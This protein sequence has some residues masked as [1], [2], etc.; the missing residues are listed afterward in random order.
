MAMSPSLNGDMQEDTAI[1]EREH[2]ELDHD[3][4]SCVFFSMRFGDEHGVMPMAVQLRSALYERGYYAKIV[5]MVSGGD[6][7]AEVFRWIEH[8][9]TF[10]V[11]GS[12]H[13]GENTGNQ[14]CTY[15]EYKHAFGKKKRI[16]LIRMIPSSE[17]FREL[18]AR[19]IFNANMMTLRWTI[20]TPMHPD[21]ADRIVDA[22][23]RTRSSR[24]PRKLSLE[25]SSPRPVQSDDDNSDGY[26]VQITAKVQPA[27]R[28]RPLERGP[29]R[30]KWVGVLLVAAV[31]ACWLGRHRIMDGVRLLLKRM[32]EK[33]L[34]DPAPSPGFNEYQGMIEEMIEGVG[35]VLGDAEGWT[36]KDL[37]RH[38]RM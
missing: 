27:S 38:G 8:C 33:Y 19:V 14:A 7:D 28:D 30:K 29:A 1:A 6:I 26:G 11:F 24:S 16:I 2:A 13:Y 15:Y 22:I 23:A 4:R 12:R 3:S 17:E 31:T 20:G 21:L 35:R 9:D 18:Q 5:D 10:V 37:G 32:K 34:T 25:M 36:A